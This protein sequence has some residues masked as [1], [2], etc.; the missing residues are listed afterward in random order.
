MRLC[1]ITKLFDLLLPMGGHRNSSR[2][3]C[4]CGQHRVS[5]VYA[6]EPSMAAC[7]TVGLVELWPGYCLVGGMGV[8]GQLC[9]SL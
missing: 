4:A 9:L 6:T 3:E 1:C 5:G 7:H 8:P 2:G